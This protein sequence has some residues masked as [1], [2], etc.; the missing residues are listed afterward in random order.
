MNGLNSI[1]RSC[2]SNSCCFALYTDHWD[3]WQTQ[4][5]EQPKFMRTLQS[6]CRYVH[7][8]VGLYNRHGAGTSFR[9]KAWQQ[10]PTLLILRRTCLV[11]RY[12]HFAVV[13]EEQGA[14]LSR[15]C[16]IRALQS[17]T[18][19]ELVWIKF[20]MHLK[21]VS[22]RV[23]LCLLIV[24][25]QRLLKRSPWQTQLAQTTPVHTRFLALSA[26]FYW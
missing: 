12:P 5:K 11:Y 21:P 8:C 15:W 7:T 2:F 26:L 14:W 17:T 4:G 19:D 3:W 16:C 22:A 24:P 13:T 1:S 23:Y 20:Y 10:T 6:W 9:F 18:Y 25:Y